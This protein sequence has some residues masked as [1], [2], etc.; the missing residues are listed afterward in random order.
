MN[1]IAVVGAS[2]L[3]GQYVAAEAERRGY[4]VMGTYFNTE[5]VSVGYRSERM[6]IRDN[7][8]TREVLEGFSPDAILLTAAMTAVD[9]CERRPNEAWRVNVEGTLNVASISK[10]LGAKMLYI[11]TDY[12]F[13]GDKGGPY[14]ERDVPDPVNIYARTKYQGEQITLDASARNLVCRVSVLYG[15]N[16]LSDGANFVTWV[17]DSLEEENQIKLF[18]DQSVSPTYVPHCATVLLDLVES[19]SSGVFHTSGPSCV[20]RY[21]MGEQIAEVFSLDASLLQPSSIEEAEWIAARP[22]CSCLDVS[23]LEA[24]LNTAVPSF[25]DSLQDMISE[26]EID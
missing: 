5:P 23:K 25:R 13:R 20:N 10:A 24:S 1:R 17:I 22:R 3:L 26:E 18:D 11:S 12:V 15:W 14:T 9:E 8:Q 6:D 19:D 2:G 16:R 21:Q 4:E 7:T